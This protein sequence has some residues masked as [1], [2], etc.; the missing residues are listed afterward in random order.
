MELSNSHESNDNV[1][2]ESSIN[3]FIKDPASNADMII[4]KYYSMIGPIKVNLNLLFI[5]IF[6]KFDFNKDY[7]SLVEQSEKNKGVCAK[8]LDENSIAW[9]CA[10]CEN[11]PNAIM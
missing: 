8:Q 9:R 6:G 10:T 7:Q 5:L 4:E 1:S 11:D 2:L 3:S